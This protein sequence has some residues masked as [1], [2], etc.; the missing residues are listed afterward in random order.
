MP[1]LEVRGLVKTYNNR[2]VVDGVDFHV[3]KGEIVGLLG[4][5]GAGKTTSFRI[6]MGLIRSEGGYVKLNGQDI[7]RLVTFRRARCGMGYLSQEPSVFRNMTVEDNVIA[8]LETQNL[9]R[10][11]SRERLGELLG[12]M[13]LTRLAKSM[14]HTLSGGE[15]RRLEICR[16]LVASPSILL[17]DEPFSGVDPRACEDIQKIIHNL[18]RR[19]ISILLTDHNV[20]ETFTIVDRA[21]IIRDGKVLKHGT[22]QEL[23][24]DE[25]ARR[26]YL[27]DKFTEY[28]E[29]FTRL[30]EEIRRKGQDAPVINIGRGTRILRQEENKDE[31]GPP[32]PVAS[33]RKKDT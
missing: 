16:A 8:I 18:Q 26:L 12:D 27:G 1:L 21:Y 32:P 28:G 20:F 7:S 5:N 6:V 22:P 13:N 33:S 23:I 31:G 25:D 19:G 24:E 3:A 4:P 9:T 14:A 11:A 30:R 2:R 17:L 29:A 15:R 10:A